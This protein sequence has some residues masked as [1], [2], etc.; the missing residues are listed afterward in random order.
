MGNPPVISVTTKEQA[1]ELMKECR[2]AAARQ[3]GKYEK[4]VTEEQAQIIVDK[5]S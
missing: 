3:I 4:T 2:L 5:Q 1:E